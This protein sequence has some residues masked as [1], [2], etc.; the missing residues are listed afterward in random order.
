[1]N[2]TR[3]QSIRF[4]FWMVLLVSLFAW[5]P[6]TYPG[7]WESLAG[8]API[9]NSVHV[10]AIADIATT[11]DLWRGTGS[12]AYLLVQPLLL[13]GVAPAAA[14]RMSFVVCFLLGGLGVY[15]WLQ[16]RLGD[17]SASLAAILYMLWPPLLAT[18]YVRG[19]LSDALVLGL[20]P[21]ALAGISSYGSSRSPSAVGAVVLSLLW[22]WRTQAGLAVFVTLILLLYVTVVERDGWATLVVLV[23]GAAGLAS[24]IPLWSITG[25]APIA[26]AEH[27][28]YLFQLFDPNVSSI[29]QV[30][31]SAPGWQDG[32]PFQLGFAIWGFGVVALWGWITQRSTGHDA[33]QE[34][35][36]HAVLGRLWWFAS[37]ASL[38]LIALSLRVSAPLWRWSGADRLLTY[39]WQVTLLAGPF[40]ALLAGSLP[41]IYRPLRRRPYWAVLCTLAV[42]SSYAYLLPAYISVEPPREPVAIL[43]DEHN[44]VLLE[45]HV[46]QAAP[47]DAADEPTQA[48]LD[49]TWQTLH[50]L[51][52]DYNVFFQAL[53][54][55]EDETLNV[56]AQ[57]DAQPLAG[58]R[59]V[60]TWRVG[61]I[62]TDTYR[63]DLPPALD[64]AA[65]EYHFGYYD[66][67]DGSRLPVR[68]GITGIVD[69][70][71]VLD[72]R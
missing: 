69:D 61:E 41:A 44:A 55:K 50:P 36:Q 8:F 12:A 7:Y 17:P 35:A 11:P 59:P 31:P 52:F 2:S 33:P 66:W 65:L 3:S 39:P 16:A 18:V 62:L 54:E 25:P 49:V 32:Y 71:L 5:A 68:L 13:L 42:L 58:E 14:V 6:A 4:G 57:L 43:G 26:F 9:F 21:L 70:K 27:F 37:I 45:A 51:D 20:F 30:A 72:G 40:L 60:T 24:L 23:S 38:V 10:S 47:A 34:T 28:V 64:P 22:M 63:L 15:V 48:V 56:V 1:M 29:G 19:S 46:T 53:S 67:R